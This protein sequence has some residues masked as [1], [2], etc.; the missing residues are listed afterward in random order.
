MN[1]DV[2]SFKSELGDSVVDL[3]GKLIDA[4][5]QVP[6]VVDDSLHASAC[7]ANESAITSLGCPS[8]AARLHNRPSAMRRAHFCRRFDTRRETDGWLFL[9]VP[10]LQSFRIYLDVEVSELA[11][12]APFSF[13]KMLLRDDVLVPVTVM[14]ISPSCARSPFS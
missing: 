4:G 13:F 6:F 1:Y 10:F 3:F 9:I 14:K 11:R 7:P 8:A 5:W 12:I 2:L